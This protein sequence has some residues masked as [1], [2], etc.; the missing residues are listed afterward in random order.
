MEAKVETLLAFPLTQI[1]LTSGEI[2]CPSGENN[3]L[4]FQSKT[5]VKDLRQVKDPYLRYSEAI[6]HHMEA[7]CRNMEVN[8]HNTE[9]I[10]H[11]TEAIHHHTEAISE[12]R[13]LLLCSGN[14]L[15]CCGINHLCGE[16]ILRSGA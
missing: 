13:K 8:S 12:S 4:L 2:P 15:P 10:H 5:R 14:F 11:H 9:A 16:N 1:C 6:C 3:I 7:I